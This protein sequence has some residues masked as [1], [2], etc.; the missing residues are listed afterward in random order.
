MTAQFSS[1]HNPFLAQ[2]YTWSGPALRYA[3]RPPQLP[4][5]YG[6]Q[7]APVLGRVSSQ[8]AQMPAVAGLNPLSWLREDRGILWAPEVHAPFAPY[9]EG[10]VQ[11]YSYKREF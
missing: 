3:K 1:N 2:V 7:A 8:Q 11:G 10:T 4:V 5:A 9:G 6:K